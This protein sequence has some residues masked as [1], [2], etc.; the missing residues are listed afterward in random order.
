MSTSAAKRRRIDAASSALSKPFRSPFK[1]PF[2]SP[3]KA[4]PS[5]DGTQ[6]V[7]SANLSS[8]IPVILNDQSP[9]PAFPTSTPTLPNKANNIPASGPGPLSTPRAK[10]IFT[11][12]GQVAALNLDPEIGQLLRK[13][14]DLEKRLREVKEALD[15]AQQAR[16]IEKDSRKK[17]PEGVV[18]GELVELFEKW[19]AASRQAAEELFG[20]VRDRVNRYVASAG[21]GKEML[22]GER[23]WEVVLT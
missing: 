14:R 17:D 7:N 15:T 22:L 18:D 2:K 8:S 1:T 12:P 11:S 19:K 6:L 9:P 3:L 21:L 13:Q 16:K 20:K 4:Q 5:N 10:K 23:E